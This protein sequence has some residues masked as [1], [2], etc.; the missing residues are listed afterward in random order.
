MVMAKA[1]LV[2]KN[3]AK[4]KPKDKVK[5]KKKIPLSKVV[6]TINEIVE[7]LLVLMKKHIGRENAISKRKL[8]TLVY[9]YEPE[10]FSELQEFM[11]WEL[12]KKAMHRCRQQTHA[13]IVS[14]IWKANAYSAKDNFGGVW[15]YWVAE[16]ITDFQTYRDNINRNIKAMRNMVNKCERAVDQEWHKKDWSTEWKIKMRSH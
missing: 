14:Q 6:K 16:D 10:H 2:L 7:K 5:S 9:G 8:F 11:M 13:F 12:I 15:H 1:K 3:K 4:E